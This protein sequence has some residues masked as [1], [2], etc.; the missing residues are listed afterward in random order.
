[1]FVA[2]AQEVSPRPGGRTPRASLFRIPGEM[3]TAV[4]D[5]AVPSASGALAFT[6]P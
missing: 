2:P 3:C 6:S 5:L 1:M 4:G